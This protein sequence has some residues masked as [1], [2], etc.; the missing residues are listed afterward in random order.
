MRLPQRRPAVI[1]A[2]V[3][4]VTLAAT[5]VAGPAAAQVTRVR[6]LAFGT[7]VT[8]ATTSVAVTGTG[9]AMWRIHV[10][11]VSVLGS[12]ALTL[13]T[14]LTRSGGG[15]TMPIAFCGTCGRY[16]VNSSSVAGATT[17]NPNTTVTFA[18]LA[19]G[20]DVYVWLGGAVS[21]PANQPP[22]SYSGT[23]VITTSGLI[24]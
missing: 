24:I 15:G 13:P 19:L 11:L 6:D 18:S 22:G 10:T 14:A 1:V 8:G 5:S 23:I 16:R 7:V 17:F 3:L 9:A 2:L 4:A 21:P 12:F 20:S